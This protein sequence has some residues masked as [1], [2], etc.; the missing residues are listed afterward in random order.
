MFQDTDRITVPN[1]EKGGKTN[2]YPTQHGE[3]WTERQKDRGKYDVDEM[4]TNHPLTNDV[5]VAAWIPG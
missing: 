2:K 3:R 1:K 5:V 4:F